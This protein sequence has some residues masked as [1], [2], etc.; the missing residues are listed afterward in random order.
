MFSGCKLSELVLKL[1]TISNLYTGFSD[2]L[3][4]LIKKYSTF[5]ESNVNTIPRQKA[6]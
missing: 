4:Y 5:G 2:L 3:L 6:W 1:F